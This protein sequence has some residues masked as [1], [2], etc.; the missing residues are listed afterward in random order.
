M[1]WTLLMLAVA[2]VLA[3]QASA[4]LYDAQQ[5][6]FFHYPA[7][8]CPSIDDPAVA[9]LT[10]AFFGVPVIWLIGLGLIALARARKR[11]REPMAPHDGAA[12]D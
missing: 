12:T 3:V 1:A 8:A 4:S 6:C 5:A 11:R 9:R 10:F 7:V 2:V